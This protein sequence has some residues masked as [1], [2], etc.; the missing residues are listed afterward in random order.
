MLTAGLIG[1]C[2]IAVAAFAA[3]AFYVGKTSVTA[4]ATNVGSPAA[5]AQPRFVRSP[6]QHF[7][8]WNLVCGHMPGGP[9]E[10]YLALVV[11]D[12]TRKHLVLR[13][14]VVQTP[15]GPAMLA[16]TP[17]NALVS[18]GFTLTP[19]KGKPI[20]APFIRCVPRACQAAFRL[21][22]DVSASLKAA[23]GAQASFVSGTDTP[24]AFHFPI[25]GFAAGYAAWAAQA[26]KLENAPEKNSASSKGSGSSNSSAV[27]AKSQK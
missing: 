14:S 26:P 15:K 17:P 12:A 18:P 7:G 23:S 1:A 13:L 9:K 11:A 27:E 24:V 25:T 22:D 5:N 3:I 10:C 20:T 8:Q 19:D 16:L 21:S 6:P 2:L 4:P